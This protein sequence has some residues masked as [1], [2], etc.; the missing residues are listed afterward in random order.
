MEHG[1]RNRLEKNEGR[2][3]GRQ[4]FFGGRF[5]RSGAEDGLCLERE[6]KQEETSEKKLPG[7]VIKNRVSGKMQEKRRKTRFAHPLYQV[8][9]IGIIRRQIGGKGAEGSDS[10]REGH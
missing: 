3:R 1:R 5:F 4:A 9:G 8:S 10:R 7:Q 6:G 2:H